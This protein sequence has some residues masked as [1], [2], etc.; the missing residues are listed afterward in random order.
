MKSDNINTLAKNELIHKLED[1]KKQLMELQFKRR[2]GAEKPHM[3]NLI[4]KDIARILTILREK[5]EETK[6]GQ[7]K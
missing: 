7:K 2:S 1:F 3:F 4:R 6:N 5:E